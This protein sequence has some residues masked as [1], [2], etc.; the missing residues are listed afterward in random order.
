MPNIPR[1]FVLS[2]CAALASNALA[3]KAHA[4]PATPTYHLAKSW[5]LPGDSFWDYLTLDAKSNRLYIT[6]DT[7]IQVID[8]RSGALVGVVNGLE[9]VHGVAISTK[10]GRGFATSGGQNR[11]V[12]FDPK[13]LKKLGE[14]KVGQGP[15]A[16][17]YEPVTGE[18]FVMN[19]DSQDIS[20]IDG[21]GKKVIATIKVGSNG[22]SAASDGRGNLFVNIE[23]TS[24]LAQIN[25]RTRKLVHL[26]PLAPGEEPTGLSYDPKT[27]RL[28]SGCANKKMIV[29]SAVTGKILAQIP[30]GAGV[31]AGA[32]DRKFGYAFAPN[33]RD[34]TLSIVGDKAGKPA[35]LATIRT[36]KGARTMAL[37]PISHAIYVVAA[38]Y[39]PLKPG[40]R[41]PESV[42]GSTVLL[43]LEPGAK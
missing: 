37:D 6:R 8:T 30:V 2:L 28:Y 1:A 24:K 21:A 3:L 9:E 25:A 19:R 38:D 22:E 43:K 20:V 18:L 33:G 29:V 5:K 41:Y 17:A 32:F 12:I 11:V 35:L 23:G 13:T 40:A 4:A 10:L 27:A 31:D 39:Q 42:P 14:I 26:Y 36:H 16:I 7:Q 34:G 15:D